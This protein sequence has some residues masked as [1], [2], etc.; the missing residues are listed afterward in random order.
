MVDTGSG[1]TAFPCSAC[2]NCGESYHTD[3]YFI[4]ADSSTFKKLTCDSPCMR[5]RCSGSGSCQICR[6]SMSYQ[7]GSSWSAY[8]AIDLAYAGGPHDEPLLDSQTGDGLEPKHASHFAFPLTFGCQTSLTGLFRTQ[9]ADGIMGM[10][11]AN[12][13]FWHQMY[14]KN[15]IPER[16]F[17]LCFN[18]QPIASKDGTMAGAVT[19]GGED[20][21]LHTSPMLFSDNTRNS[22]F[23]TVRLKKMYIRE[24]GGESAY[25]TDKDKIRPIDI[26]EATLNSGG[27]IVDSG[28][29]DTYM[30]RHLAEPFKKLWEDVAGRKYT[31]DAITLTDDQLRSLPTV[32]FQLEG[33]RDG[34]NDDMPASF[35]GTGLAEKLDPSNPRDVLI[36]LPASHYMEFDSEKKKY[37]SRLYLEEGSGSVLG[38]NAMM[39]HDVL[40]D[41]DNNRI[42][43][44]ESDCDYFSLIG[45]ETPSMPKVD[46]EKLAEEGF[47]DVMPGEG[48]GTATG[49][50]VSEKKPYIV[51]AENFVERVCPSTGCKA[52]IVFG[53]VAMF[54]VFVTYHRYR[55]SK[56]GIEAIPLESVD[57]DLQDGRYED[58]PGTSGYHDSVRGG[59][60][61]LTATGLKYGGDSG[62]GVNGD[63]DDDYVEGHSEFSI[64]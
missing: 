41:I 15:A 3:S 51:E 2:N 19:L 5:G 64:T 27:V 14:D 60:T 11:N 7:E 9:L 13:A 8:E 58:P 24:G 39:G 44:A 30:V 25:I 37:I 33:S 50:E 20:P 36:A 54:V 34:A 31:H 6:I 48:D 40:F 46:S 17:S 18:R 55:R 12:A 26:D 16:K 4:E 57:R 1:V 21:R 53:L 61:E 35:D 28:T 10:D 23:Y 63:D 42:G 49:S 32:M 45:V 56:Y 38:A 43:W 22:G 59:E 29:T 62:A 52:G 47:E